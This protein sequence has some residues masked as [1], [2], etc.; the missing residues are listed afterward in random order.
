MSRRS[1]ILALL[2]VAFVCGFGFFND[3][4][5]RQ[6]YM[7]GTFMPMPVY[8]GLIL[9]LLLV[10]PLLRLLGRRWPL[11]GQELAFVVA[12][13]LFAC[14]IPGRGLMHHGTGTLMLPHHYAKTDTTWKETSALDLVPKRM[15]ADVSRDEDTAL[16]GFVQGLG[17]GSTHIRFR[18]I[19]WTAWHR[20]FLFWGPLLYTVVLAL[21]GLAL[22]VHRQWTA[23]EQIPYPIVTFAE[24]ILPRPGRLWGD[25]FGSRLFWIAAGA[26]F[27]VHMNNYAARW[28]PDHLIP[29]RLQF[30]FRPLVPLFPAFARGGG[31]GIAYPRLLFTVVGFAYFLSSELSLSMGLAPYAYAFFVG[32]CVGYGLTVGGNFFAL[33][34]IE[35]G[36]YGG[37]YLGIGLVMLYNGRR[38]YSSVL[39]GCFGIR[40]GDRAEPYAIWGA[41]LLLVASVAFVL[42]LASVGI[43]WQLAVL[44]TFF[45]ML[46]S[47]VLSRVVA[48]TGAFFI[49]C[50]FYPCAL[51]VTF[52]GPMAFDPK[53]LAVMFLVTV[54]LM[55]DPREI[56]MPFA[57][58]AFALLERSKVRFGPPAGWGLA[59]VILGLVVAV[60]ATLYWQYDRGAI[61]VGDGWSLNVM[62]W[63]FDN[64]AKLE[65][66]LEALGH[67]GPDMPAPPGGWARFTR[68][69]PHVAG[70][71][72]FVSALSLVLIF[73]F[74]RMRFP[75]FPL[76]PVLFLLLGSYQSRYMGFSF[77][78]GWFVKT[79]MVKYGGAHMYA[80]AK[81]LM[82]GL[83]AGEM[84]AGAV[85]M[86]IGGVYYWV[87]G[88]PPMSYIILGA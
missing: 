60:S 75:R 28:W 59:A 52:L 85:T 11:S 3:F 16:G 58:H 32:T 34:N 22:V 8:G 84:A 83:I 47:L 56:F 6:T 4:V 24:S 20:A 35:R 72:A 5:L 77:L 15:L 64:A 51:L 86:I 73:T 40:R 82:I 30:D 23:H 65:Q 46:I 25:A 36:L 70:V 80:R 1:V 71:V 2:A 88:V 21:T 62:R 44:Y 66:R 10:N 43:D 39:R 50:Y 13:V 12:V 7:V 45:F 79:M 17:E 33:E 38:Y 76:H 87:Q 67:S 48:E 54:V 57:V 26:V 78:V 68:A 27:L 53:T 37:A 63:P 19:P 61:S 69:K 9:F 18:E 14:F 81:P 74:C 49:H 29:V 41:R 42:Q 55:I 31:W